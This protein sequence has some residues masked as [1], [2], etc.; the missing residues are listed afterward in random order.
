LRP[1]HYFFIALV[2]L[3]MESSNAQ[4]SRERMENAGNQIKSILSTQ[5]SGTFH[6]ECIADMDSLKTDDW[7]P[8]GLIRDPYRTLARSFPFIAQLAQTD[9]SGYEHVIS[10]IKG[11]KDSITVFGVFREG[12]IIWLT[13]LFNGSVYN[14]GKIYGI[15]DINKDGKVEIM[16]EWSLVG[17]NVDQSVLWIFTWD[18]STATPIYEKQNNGV[19][20][21][22]NIESM[23]DIE[24]DGIIEFVGIKNKGL[25]DDSGNSLEHEA[26]Y[27]W[28]GSLYGEWPSGPQIGQMKY[29]RADNFQAVVKSIIRKIDT[30]FIY[31][32][33]IINNASS[34]Q[35]L[36]C[37][38]VDDDAVNTSTIPPI[39]W[40]SGRLK[41]NKISS[42]IGLSDS[43]WIKPSCILSGF[44][45]RSTGLPCI[46]N[47]FLQAP[48]DLL[49]EDDNV[50]SDL[51]SW[52]LS[53]GY[54]NSL[55]GATIAPVDIMN[56]FVPLKFLDT[57]TGYA[58][59]S[60]SLGW[61][62]DQPT[63][64]KYLGY[65]SIARTKLVQR[66]SAGARNVLL[67]VLHDVDIDS[68]STLTSEAYALLRFNTEYL[69]NKLP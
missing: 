28:N 51:E 19:S 62:K 48:Y 27:S 38:L 33:S 7:L 1:K 68:A 35:S 42:F 10:T 8:S 5:Y 65:F 25:L 54:I 2:S 36:K 60:R 47:F 45:V 18:G 29:T 11:H 49:K 23:V 46:M 9:S 4:T 66:D 59:Q 31:N 26:V 14:M 57:L 15:S 13:T 20:N 17:S 12:Q 6:L 32:Y 43:A 61:I 34:K 64:D 50:P 22:E 3:L 41:K 37:F 24:G 67:Q 53:K 56:P 40:K 30:L 39:N 69:V 44:Q 21:L 63:E 58:T 16:I 52:F 55:K